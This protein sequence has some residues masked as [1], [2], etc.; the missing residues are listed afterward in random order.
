ML[1]RT[2]IPIINDWSGPQA[3]ML[4]L[5]VFTTQIGGTKPAAIRYQTLENDL[6]HLF[7][8]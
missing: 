3:A 1:F 6:E 7:Q 8:K 2:Y 5:G 4:K